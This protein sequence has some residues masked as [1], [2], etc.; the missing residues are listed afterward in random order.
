[1]VRHPSAAWIQGVVVVGLYPERV[2]GHAVTDRRDG[3]KLSRLR[4]YHPAQYEGM[5]RRRSHGYGSVQAEPPPS[6]S[7]SGRG[8]P[9]GPALD[10]HLVERCREG[11]GGSSCGVL[12]GG[13]MGKVA[14][15]RVPDAYRVN[16][17]EWLGAGAPGLVEGG[18]LREIFERLLRPGRVGSGEYRS[19]VVYLK[20][21]PGDSY[22]ISV[23]VSGGTF[24]FE[25][26][27]P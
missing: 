10:S 2:R 21:A 5:L 14:S 24:D 3:P 12:Y 1:M 17:G 13:R 26:T 9:K 23:P 6:M 4:T 18:G 16:R 25:F 22:R 27:L 20:F 15:D 8:D 11:G 7:G 19:G